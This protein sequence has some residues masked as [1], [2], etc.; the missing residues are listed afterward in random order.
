MPK[1]TDSDILEVISDPKLYIET[2]LKI[3]AKQPGL[4]PFILNAPQIDFLNA[5]LRN[6]RIIGLKARQIGFST[7]ASAYLYWKTI[8]TPGTTCALIAHKSDVAA[9]FFRLGSDGNCRR[10]RGK[11]W[12]GAKAPVVRNVVVLPA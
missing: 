7:F 4:I 6:N 10:A 1:I 5:L 2:Y 8:T 11:T 3:K 9:E 12:F